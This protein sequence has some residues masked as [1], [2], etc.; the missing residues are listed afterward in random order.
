MCSDPLGL[1]AWGDSVD[2]NLVDGIT[3]FGDGVFA[4]VTFG[5]GDLNQSRNIVGIDGSVD[6]SCSIYGLSKF[7]G[8]GVGSEALGG[9]LKTS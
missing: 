3:G 9:A 2:Q 8:V 5:I 1:W 6:T 4:A 7:V